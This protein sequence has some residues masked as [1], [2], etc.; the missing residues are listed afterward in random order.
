MG[1]SEKGK[2]GLPT[3]LFQC[4]LELKKQEQLP[5]NPNQDVLCFRFFKLEL[6]KLFWRE[7]IHHNNP[8]AAAL[9]SKMGYRQEEKVRVKLEFLRMLTRL[10]CDPARMEL[11]AGFFEAYLKLSRQ[12]EE[13]LSQELGR[14][15][16]R[17][18]DIIMQITTSWHE[19][20]KIEGICKFMTRRF[21]A[22]ADEIREKVQ[23]VTNPEFLDVV[24]EEVFAADTL[25][26]AQSIIKRAVGKSLQ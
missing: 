2:K 24:M 18:A 5:V 15:D 16:Q 13:Q 23:Q 20:G 3:L 6:K 17:E 10:K 1:F 14:I 12:E 21:N 22:D 11:I 4:K 9:L 26:E 19:K 7:Y 25:E 8:V